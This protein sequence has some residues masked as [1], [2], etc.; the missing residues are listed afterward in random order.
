MIYSWWMLVIFKFK[1]RAVW[2]AMYWYFELRTQ[3]WFPFQHFFDLQTLKDKLSDWLQKTNPNSWQKQLLYYTVLVEAKKKKLPFQNLARRT[4]TSS[5]WRI[6]WTSKV[7][8]NQVGKSW[9]GIF[10]H[11]TWPLGPPEGHFQTSWSAIGIVSIL[12]ETGSQ[13]CRV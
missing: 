4:L 9:G 12:K 8:D 1:F 10:I 11:P 7:W 2:G 13:K 3:H 6:S 5:P